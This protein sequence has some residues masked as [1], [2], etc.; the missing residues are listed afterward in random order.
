MKSYLCNNLQVWQR[1]HMLVTPCVNSN[2]IA[3]LESMEELGRV[4]ENVYADHE[5]RRVDIVGGQK[6]NEFGGGLEWQ[7]E[8]CA[9]RQRN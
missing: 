4:V 7:S 9:N 6:V 8:W 2:V 1:R 3:R 5:M